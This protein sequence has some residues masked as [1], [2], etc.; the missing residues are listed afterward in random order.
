MTEDQRQLAL[1]FL[2]A[3]LSQSGY[4]KATKIMAL[5]AVLREIEIL[6]WLGRDPEKYFYSFFGQ[7][8]ETNTWGWRVEGH[9]LSLN[10]TIVK[11]HLIATAPRF[12]GANPAEVFEGDMSGV[13]TLFNEESLARKLV[14]SLDQKQQGK[15][16][17]R[18]R[19]YRDIVTGNDEKV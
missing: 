3:G 11:G 7:A 18:K 19:A 10:L 13:R 15:A 17:F 16:V 6:N 2:K 5:E 1:Q 8:S 14:T 9:H 4:L 12:L